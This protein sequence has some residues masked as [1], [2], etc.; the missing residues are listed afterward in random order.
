ML[1]TE[2]LI[3]RIK[4]SNPIENVI[5][6]YVQLKRSGRSMKGLCPFHSEKTP[7]FYVNSEQGFYHCFGCK[8]SGDVIKFIQEIEHLEFMDALEL[9]AKRSN[10]D[11]S[12]Y[13]RGASNRSVTTTIIHAND[14]A[15]AHYADALKK[16]ER[17][18]SM[19]KRRG[20]DNEGV[21]EFS[22]GYSDST[23]PLLRAVRDK[24]LNEED[25]EKAGLIVPD[26]RGGKRDYFFNR[27]M[28]P[29][30]SA[31][32]NIIGFGARALG[33]EQPK[34]INSAENNVFKKGNFLYG[35]HLS[36]KH[37]FD[38]NTAV[39][40]EGYMDFISLYRSGVKNCAAQLGT[41]CTDNQAAILKKMAE[42]VVIMYDSD[43]AGLNAAMRSIPILLKSGLAVYVFK[44]SQF[45]DPDELAASL[46]GKMEMSYIE[47]RSSDFISFAK[48]FFIRTQ[49]D[50]ML[51][52]KHFFKYTADAI[53]G[54]DDPVM[55]NIYE[56]EAYEKHSMPL[57][58]VKSGP[59]EKAQTKKSPEGMDIY[60]EV[61]AMMCSDREIKREFCIELSE[62]DMADP[63]AKGLF[64]NLCNTI[65]A[66]ESTNIDLIIKND[67]IKSLKD[68]IIERTIYYQEKKPVHRTV[69][70]TVRVIKQKRVE[71]KIEEIDFKIQHTEDAEEKDR[72]LEQRIFLQNKVKGGKADV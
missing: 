9:L 62:E 56:K 25:F 47:E 17:V 43:N 69:E 63:I 52:K 13:M 39:L 16:S 72:L 8:A 71:R 35:L 44:Y 32:G 29:I 7:S 49:S 11:I 67:K 31:S 58:A 23:F 18:K 6:E 1:N 59:K 38:A 37:I 64:V 22:L 70:H 61:I 65:D 20:L 40:V 21:S 4:E 36:K 57:N 10:I 48:D 45:K 68:Y 27:I 41:A 2:D 14:F 54:I 55:R 50:E 42:R 19:L 60:S 46:G 28:F 34:Y 12:Q 15:S 66:S 26:G 5:G 3:Y 51:A 33:D 53:S 24:S 30:F